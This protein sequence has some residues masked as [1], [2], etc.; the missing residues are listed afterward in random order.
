MRI[1]TWSDPL[2]TVVNAIS[3]EIAWSR[4]ARLGNMAGLVVRFCIDGL[5]RRSATLPAHH[6]VRDLH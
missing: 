4:S 1:K 2:T 5:P 3:L 6:G